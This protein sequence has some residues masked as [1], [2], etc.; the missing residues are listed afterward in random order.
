[1]ANKEV[2]EIKM[3]RSLVSLVAVP[4]LVAACTSGQTTLRIGD[5]AIT[6][7]SKCVPQANSAVRDIVID[8]GKALE[9]A[10]QQ[11]GKLAMFSTD[12]SQYLDGNCIGPVYQIVDQK[13]G[14]GYVVS[15]RYDK[16]G[17]PYFVFY[18]HD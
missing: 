5:K 8:E 10:R 12:V 16:L 13:F 14:E 6:L 1:M 18:K 2:V 7:D 15:L 9:S 4:A 17:Q 3:N 11:K